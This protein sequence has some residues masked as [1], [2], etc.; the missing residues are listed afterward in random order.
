MAK[1]VLVFRQPSYPPHNQ[2]GACSL[3]SSHLFSKTAV[4]VL[5]KRFFFYGKGLLGQ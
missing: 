4:S 3:N 1:D 2:A 5:R